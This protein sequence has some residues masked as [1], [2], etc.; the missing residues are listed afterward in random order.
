MY[1]KLVDAENNAVGHIV[2]EIT[3]RNAAYLIQRLPLLKRRALH[4]EID[5]K[6]YKS[7][8]ESRACGICKELPRNYPVD[9]P[10]PFY[11]EGFPIS[12]V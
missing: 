11:L 4:W 6:A 10:S 8:L 12:I 1:A 7:L 5:S 9:C 3:D 2:G